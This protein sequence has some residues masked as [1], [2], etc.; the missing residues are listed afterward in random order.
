L[1]QWDGVLQTCARALEMNPCYT[2][3]LMLRAR[4]QMNSWC[5]SD[6]VDTYRR[7][8]KVQ[9]DALAGARA[10]AEAVLG[11]SMPKQDGTGTEAQ[12]DVDGN[13]GMQR[14][15]EKHKLIAAVMRDTSLSKCPL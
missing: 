15:A 12:H 1:Q 2:K 13:V 4:A 11:A 5:V 8:L 7:A 14:E 9:E 6:A 3:A 10:R